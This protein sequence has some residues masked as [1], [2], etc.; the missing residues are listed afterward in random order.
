[1]LAVHWT[2]V[3]KTKK[4]LKKGIKKN[5]NGVFCFPLTGHK[6]IDNWWVS[7]FNQSNVRHKKRYNGIVFRV[8]EEDLPA[9]FGSWVGATN[10]DNFKK[11]ITDLKTLNKE[12]RNNILYRMGAE[13][14][15]ERNLD[16]GIFDMNALNDLYTNLAEEEL[17]KNPNALIDRIN[18]LEF[19]KYALED[20]QIVL[21]KSIPPERIIKIKPK[22]NEFGKVLK[23]QKKLRR[24]Y[25]SYYQ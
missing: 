2:P 22:G 12:Y 24:K 19:M 17:N 9:Y 13:I 10:K 18:S 4:V 16:C 8:T 20:Y 15:Y 21:S 25:P 11:E 1:M 3:N 6:P 14:A 23:K 5:K 7:F